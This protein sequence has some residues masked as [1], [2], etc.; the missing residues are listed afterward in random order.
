MLLVH[1][2]LYNNT[3]N[4][5]LGHVTSKIIYQGDALYTTEKAPPRNLQI[6]LFSKTQILGLYPGLLNS[7]QLAS[8]VA[9][10]IYT[11]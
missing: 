1:K 7:C 10:E 9:A 2:P 4:I 8:M 3:V 11:N 5:L 6:P